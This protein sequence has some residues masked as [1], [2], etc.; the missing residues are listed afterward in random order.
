MANIYELRRYGKLAFLVAAAGVVAL[1]LAFSD[2]LIR[3]LSQQ[4]RERM[5][6]WADAT[7]QLLAAT[8]GAE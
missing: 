4:E 7:Q 2:S 3:D 5:E 8:S 1:F 6:I